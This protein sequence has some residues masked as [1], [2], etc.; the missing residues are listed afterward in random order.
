MSQAAITVPV[1]KGYGVGRFGQIH[2]RISQPALAAGHTPL[3]CFHMS[4]NSG[5][6]YET[7]LKHMGAD[8]FVVAPDTPGFG[9]S[10]APA[11]QPDIAD[12]AAAMGDLMDALGF[13]AVE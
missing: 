12:Y 7:F 3:L 10:D 5:R 2:Y 1:R 9:D 13:A 11:T 4:P 6:I 8:R